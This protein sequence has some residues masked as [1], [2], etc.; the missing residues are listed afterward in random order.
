VSSPAFSFL[1]N[2]PPGFL[3][4]SFIALSARVFLRAAS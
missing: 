2:D 4:L 1:H 3:L